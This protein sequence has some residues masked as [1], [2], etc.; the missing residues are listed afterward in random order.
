MLASLAARLARNG[1]GPW[2]IGKRIVVAGYDQV[3]EALARDLEF[4]IAPINGKR[5][6]EVDDAFVLGMD[7]GAVLAHE[8]EALYRALAAVDR[9]ALLQRIETE[10][11][12]R[13]AG[14]DEID[15]VNGY[16]RPV[17]AHT[18]QALFGVTGDDDRVY[19]D[20][21]RA[22]F[23]HT[24]LNLS[25]NE[26]VGQRAL[27]ASVLM[28]RW[29]T[30]EVERRIE[31]GEPGDDMMG[32]LIAQGMLDAH[33]VVRTLG[34]MLVGAVDT[35]A[36]SAA[37]IVAVI[38][39][40]RKLLA[41]VAADADDPA[42]MRGWCWEALRLWPHNPAVLREALCTTSLGGKTIA[43]GEQLL[44]FTQ[45]AMQ[46]A[47]AFPDPQRLRPDRPSDKYLHFGG[48]LHVCAG[49][50]INAFQIPMLV[51]ALVRRG[52]VSAGKVAWAGPFPDRLIVRLEK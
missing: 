8:R 41:K 11:A 48:A 17:A 4:G 28:R 37:K 30:E 39:G 15:V 46:D 49:R 22:I 32:A 42:R 38:G 51:T 40:D 44:L 23:A 3:R 52:I 20:V 33:G 16:A 50:S 27:R 19:M 29:L 34:G 35:T 5:I 21:A 12:E 13:L 31:L 36:S 43:K 10:I 6:A 2:R 25:G 9:G 14:V 7:R 18:A 47:S 26:A 24:F 1:R 45:A